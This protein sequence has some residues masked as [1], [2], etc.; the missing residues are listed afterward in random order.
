MH[1]LPSLAHLIADHPDIST[2]DVSSM[3]DVQIGCAVLSETRTKELQRHMPN[4]TIRSGTI[5]VTLYNHIR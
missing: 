3:R 2:Y 4:A 1:I 5:T